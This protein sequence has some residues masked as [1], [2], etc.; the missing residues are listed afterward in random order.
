[1]RSI[2]Y[3][4]K[5]V[6][7][8]DDFRAP[9]NFSL[10]KSLAS[11][12]YKVHVVTSTSNH[13]STAFDFK[14]SSLTKSIDGVK[15]TWLKTVGYTKTNSFRRIISWLHFELKVI[16]MRRSALV[17]ADYVFASSLS[18]L[19][20]ISGY[21]L[22]RRLSAKFIFEVRDIW[23][24][25]LVD[26]GGYRPNNLLILMLGLIE[27]FAYIKA[28]LIIGTMPNLQAHVRNVAP[29]V[30]SN[31]VCVPMGYSE[32]HLKEQ[33]DVPENYVKQYL[34]SEKFLVTHLGSVGIAN[35]L[36]TLTECCSLLRQY[37]NI[38]FLVVGQGDTL[39]QLKEATSDFNNITFAPSIPKK[40][41]Q[42]LLKKSDLLYFS[43]S[44]TEIWD[45]GQSLNK[46]VDYMLSGRPII[47]SYSGFATMINESHC[48]EFV[49]AENAG[50]LAEKILEYSQMP[51]AK[52]D[53][54]GLNGQTWLLEHR[55]YDKLASGLDRALSSI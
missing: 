54:L 38:H 11:Q 7:T 29:K 53:A 44:K 49:E 46:L 35:A 55:H 2:L 12:G 43:T 31:I 50:D 45:Y 41:V 34:P 17:N 27:K 28:D 19:S 3:I 21:L 33:F 8:P 22:S 1:M 16:L 9:R 36:T 5:Y 10:M 25:T 39:T 37:S 42:S 24:L 20:V 32:Y 47:G 48:G 18:L 15:V 51:K 52:I 14:G 23:P 26:E 4:C 13:L 6:S 30:T 40:Q